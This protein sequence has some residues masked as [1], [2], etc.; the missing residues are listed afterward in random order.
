MSILKICQKKVLMETYVFF[1]KTDQ[2]FLNVQ[3]G[4]N[5]IARDWIFFQILQDILGNATQFEPH[6]FLIK[7]VK[8]L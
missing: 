1:I 3:S 5:R 4:S 2:F 7:L 6:V 8:F